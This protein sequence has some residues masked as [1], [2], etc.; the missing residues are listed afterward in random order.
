MKK[1]EKDKKKYSLRIRM[2]EINVG[3]ALVSF[4]LCGVL[5]ICSVSW[6]IAV[7]YTHL[8]LPTT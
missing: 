5:F 3:I 1:E 8:T 2:L 4:L 7:S 6:V